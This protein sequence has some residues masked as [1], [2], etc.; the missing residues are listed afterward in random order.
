[1]NVLISGMGIVSALGIGLESNIEKLINSA[2]GISTLKYLNS[3]HNGIVPVGEVK[4]SDKELIQIAGVKNNITRSS[5]LAIIAAKEALRNANALDEKDS[6][7]RTGII[8]SSTAGGMRESE[9][10]FKSFLDK[11]HSIDFMSSHDGADSTE[12]LAIELG[13]D[14]YI[15]SIN[16]ACSSSANA[17]ILGAR[18]I[19][20]NLLDRVLVGGTDGLSKFTINGFNSLLLLDKELCK[21]F[22]R[23]RRGINLGEGAGYLV[24]ESERLINERKTEPK[25]ILKGYSI[26]ND[27]FHQSATSPNGN[28]LQL[29]MKKAIK[30]ARLKNSD[31]DYINAHGTGTSNNDVDRRNRYENTFFK[32]TSF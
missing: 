11:K 10:I 22:D 32:S 6:S 24:L 21:P 18:M 5:S 13:I 7:V 20:N 12:R 28:G 1:M 23:N 2:T 16:T 14:S 17:I 9:S 4:Y 31:I 3:I 8:S 15:T 25:G 27:A 26:T 30:M 19:K 29:S